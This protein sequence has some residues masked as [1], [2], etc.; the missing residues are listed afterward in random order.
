MIDLLSICPIL[1]PRVLCCCTRLCSSHCLCLPTGWGRGR[2]AWDKRGREVYRGVG[3]EGADSGIPNG[4]GRGRNR[5]KLCIIAQ[6]GQELGLKGRGSGGLSPCPPPPTQVC[7]GFWQIKLVVT[8]QWTRIPSR[9]E[10]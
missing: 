7:S 6:I 2:G 3:E 1:Y 9:R 5:G 10:E 8:L 4:V